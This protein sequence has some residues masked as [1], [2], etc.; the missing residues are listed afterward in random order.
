M[1]TAAAILHALRCG[2][3]DSDRLRARVGA[4]EEAFLDALGELARERRVPIE[5][6]ADLSRVTVSAVEARP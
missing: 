5:G 6:N 2:P 4:D 3:L 1:N